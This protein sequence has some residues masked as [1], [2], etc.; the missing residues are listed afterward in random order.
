MVQ[1]FLT[2][3]G[4]AGANYSDNVLI[5]LREN[6]DHY[7][8]INGSNCYESIFVFR[9]FHIENLQVVCAGFK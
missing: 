5:P 6:D 3:A 1:R 2:P 9:M 8:T 7:S 4:A